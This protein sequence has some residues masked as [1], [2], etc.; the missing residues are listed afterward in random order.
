MEK[1]LSGLSFR[2]NVAF[3]E[4]RVC[5]KDTVNQVTASLIALAVGRLRE[6]DSCIGHHGINSCES[7]LTLTLL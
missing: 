1:F 3:P 4:E 7:V 2:K 6:M 5:S